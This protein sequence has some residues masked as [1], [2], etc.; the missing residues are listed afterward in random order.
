MFL[1]LGCTAL[2]GVLV[3]WVILQIGE[4]PIVLRLP[5]AIA[6]AYGVFFGLVRLWLV[7]IRSSRPDL[8][9]PDAVVEDG[10]PGGVSSSAGEVFVGKGGGFSGGGASGQWAEQAVGMKAE[11]VVAS[12]ETVASTDGLGVVADLGAAEEA[13]VVL[14]V[15]G[16]IALVVF[17]SSVYLVYEAPA[18]LSE[19]ALQMALSSSLIRAT[20]RMDQPD[21]M[22]SV[23]RNTWKPF[24]VLL[25][26]AILLGVFAGLYCPTAVRLKDLW[27]GCGG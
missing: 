11:A 21:W 23:L 5:I 24:A 4:P 27:T 15:L 16:A 17:G 9:T 18:I 12:S 7:Y 25:G 2:S 13:G 20:R 8:W 1:I 10:V 3:N 22:G 26:V 19:A 14:L 6:F